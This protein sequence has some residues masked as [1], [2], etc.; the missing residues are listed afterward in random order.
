MMIPSTC[1]Q[2]M[3]LKRNDGVLNGLSVE[4]YKTE[5]DENLPANWQQFK[6]LRTKSKQTQDVKES[7]LS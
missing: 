7:C 2:K 6:L 1:T 3:D 5:A 4:L